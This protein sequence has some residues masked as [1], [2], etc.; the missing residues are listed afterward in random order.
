MLNGESKTCWKKKVLAKPRNP[1]MAKCPRRKRLLLVSAAAVMTLA[2]LAT[3]VIA[4][5]LL[6]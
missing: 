1:S 6:R 3:L 2:T 5:Y 4:L